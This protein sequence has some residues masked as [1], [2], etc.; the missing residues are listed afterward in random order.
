MTGHAEHGTSNMVQPT[1]SLT[2]VG[3]G[4]RK[5]RSSESTPVTLAQAVT[6]RLRT[7]IMEGRFASNEKLQ[8]MSLCKLLDVS[9]TPVRAALHSL[10]AEGLLDYAPNRGYRVCSLDPDRLI[11]IFNIRAALEGLAAREAAERGMDDTALAEFRVALVQGD[12]IMRVGHLRDVDRT[13]F[14]EVNAKIH[15]AILRAADNRM[16]KDMIRMC[17]NMPIFSDRNVLWNDYDWVRRSHDDH[18]RIFDAIASRD[19]ARAEQ[20]MRE[21]VNTVKLQMKLQLGKVTTMTPA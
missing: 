16:L 1:T 20:L 6:D 17:H 9:R 4:G 15:E 7:E 8:E 19:A 3:R 5:S 12:R 2:A 13:V 21:H 18:H 14:G 10:A 11:S